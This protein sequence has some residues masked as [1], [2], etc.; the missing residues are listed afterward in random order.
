MKHKHHQHNLFFRMACDGLKLLAIITFGFVAACLF[1]AP[2]GAFAFAQILMERALPFLLR[3]ASCLV[4]ILLLA[5]FAE[6]L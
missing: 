4:C 1:L 3:L 5:G 2:F 6:S